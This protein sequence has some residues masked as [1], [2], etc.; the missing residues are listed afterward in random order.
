MQP[1][2]VRKH[3][4][5][6]SAVLLIAAAAVLSTKEARAQSDLPRFE[7]GGQVSFIDL[8]DSLR[9]KPPGV[10]GRFSYN[11]N[12]Y[13]AFDAE[14]NHFSTAEINFDRTQGLFGVKAGKRF[15][16]PHVGVFLKARPGFMHFHGE[17][18]PGVLI[19][20]TT[21]FAL[22]LGGVVEFYPSKRTVVRIDVGDTIIFYNGE[23]IRRLSLPGGPQVRLGTAHGMQS[24]IGFGFRF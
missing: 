19:N 10:G 5:P 15:G 7:V 2:Q 3:F 18:L 16:R 1:T 20:G 13:V 9:E 17:R 12:D 4:A 24:A 21:K 14:V 6:L 22:D 11:V 23:V 8:R